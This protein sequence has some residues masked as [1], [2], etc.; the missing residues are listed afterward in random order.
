MET[1]LVAQAGHLTHHILLILKTSALG[2][3]A[4]HG[5]P[6]VFAVDLRKSWQ[7][8]LFKLGKYCKLCTGT[9]ETPVVDSFSSSNHLPMKSLFPSPFWILPFIKSICFGSGE[10]VRLCF[11]AFHMPYFSIQMHYIA[12]L[13]FYRDRRPYKYLNDNFHILSQT[14]QRVRM[15][16]YLM[17]FRILNVLIS[18]QHNLEMYFCFIDHH[19]VTLRWTLDITRH[20]KFSIFA[21]LDWMWMK[22]SR[23]NLKIP[24]SKVI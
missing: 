1:D 9:N 14:A 8:L 13:D 7:S 24:P 4:R 21:L 15:R 19:K 23:N 17:W 12:L 5:F 22:L 20:K 16:C 10:K 18:C 11:R 6:I 3:G 2:R